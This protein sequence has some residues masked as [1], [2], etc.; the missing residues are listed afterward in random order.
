MGFYKNKRILITGA[1]GS[2]GSFLVK[3][4]MDR[5]ATVCAFDNYEDGLFH[6]S[7]S[8][9]TRLE[10]KFRAFFGDIRDKE[11]LI[12]ACEKVDIIFHC[13]A[14]KHVGL[15]EYNPFEAVKTNVLGCQNVIEAAIE[16]C[17]QKVLF[18][19]SDKAVNPTGTMGATKLIGEKLFVSANN[20]IGERR[21]SF[22]CVRFGNVLNT[23]GSVLTI[24]EKQLENENQL[25]V[26]D[27]RMTRFF[28]SLE[29][30]ASLCMMSVE[31]MLGGEIFILDMGCCD[32]PT[33]ARAYVGDED[34][35]Y[36]EIGGFPGEKLYEELFTETEARRT[37]ALGKFY[38]VLPENLVD[39]KVFKMYKKYGKK[40]LEN[41]LRSDDNLMAF[42]QVKAMLH[43]LNY[44][45]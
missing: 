23:N 20:Y 19:S 31:K 21:T 43:N 8:V 39:D 12:H 27:S 1:C 32:I 6:L 11:R 28:I 10:N 25:T 24:F 41:P 3:D 22:A 38:V 44:S 35:Q 26:T 14:A 9:P 45:R 7:K 15:S 37:V 42:E 5:G 36:N 4:L 30:A 18:T 29:D 17:V 34:Y 16:K 33:L 2:V 40:F 13:A